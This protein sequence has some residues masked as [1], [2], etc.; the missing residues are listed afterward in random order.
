[1]KTQMSPSGH[2]RYQERSRE[3][4]G[5]TL[6][7]HGSFPKLELTVLVRNLD[8]FDLNMQLSTQGLIPQSGSG[9]YLEKHQEVM[10]SVSSCSPPSASHEDKGRPFSTVSNAGTGP[11]RLLESTRCGV[12]GVRQTNEASRAKDDER[13]DGFVATKRWEA[14]GW[15]HSDVVMPVSAHERVSRAGIGNRNPLARQYVE[16]RQHEPPMWHHN[17]DWYPKSQALNTRPYQD[18]DRRRR[19][20]VG[21]VLISHDDPGAPRSAQ[22]RTSSYGSTE[23]S[24]GYT[25]VSSSQWSRGYHSHSSL[26]HANSTRGGRVPSAPSFISRVVIPKDIVIPKEIVPQSTNVD[27]PAEESL[28]KRYSDSGDSSHSLPT[29]KRAKTRPEPA[30][31]GKFNKLDLLCSAT[32]E[33]GPL[34][35]NPAGCSCPKSKCIA[36]YCDCF[37]AGGRC[38]PNTCSC[39]NCKNTVSESGA[40]GARS[41]VSREL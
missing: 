27:S 16:S 19:H 21:M 17:T 4:D 12:S 38:D 33:L 18:F 30:L 10:E 34:Q 23:S 3:R 25:C 31:E 26:P 29:A 20:T 35:D 36:L 11:A 7:C 2:Q 6:F 13:D 40:N 1:M 9:T 39:L 28:G 41:K 24:S 14:N 37:K 22:A 32:L 15:K 8:C 5:G